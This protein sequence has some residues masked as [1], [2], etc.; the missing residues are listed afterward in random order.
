VTAFALF[1]TSLDL[2]FT[3]TGVAYAN[4]TRGNNILCIKKWPYRSQANEDK[5]PTLL[6]YPKTPSQPYSKPP[7][8]WGFGS[9]SLTERDD[10]DKDFVEWFKIYLD[11]RVLQ[12]HQRKDP[13]GAPKLQSH[14]DKWYEDYFRLLY[15]HIELKLGSELPAHKPW[16]SAKVEF[17]V[18]LPTTWQLYPTVEKF[19][20]IIDRAGYCRYPSHSVAMGLTE[21]EAA[22]VHT[23][24][25]AAGMFNENEA[26][27][28]CDAGGGTTDLSVLRIT[29]VY[30]GYLSLQQLDVVTGKNIGSVAIDRQFE[31]YVA[32]KLQ[33]ATSMFN[34]RIDPLVTAWS[35]VRS[36]EYQN[37]KCDYGSPD[38]TPIFT[39]PI[40]RINPAFSSEQF[41]IANG[42]MKFQTEELKAIFD[43]QIT[44]LFAEIDNQLQSFQNKFPSDQIGHLVLSGGLGNS[45]YVQGQLKLR[46]AFG[47]SQFYC[48]QNIQIHVAPE[49]QLAVCKGIVSDRLRKLQ[50]GK[51]VLEWRCARASYGTLCKIL[52]DKRNP[53]H[54]SRGSFRDPLNGKYYI[55]NAIVWFVKKVCDLFQFA[56]MR[57]INVQN[58]VNLLT[59]MAIL[60]TS[61]VERLHR[62]IRLGHF[63]QVW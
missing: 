6:V 57:S 11:P 20:S 17:I 61:S 56:Q 42:T 37:A 31:D 33:Q 35:M 7:S 18:S 29:G 50:S 25:E 36:R 28:V 46:Y 15:Q 9:E 60:S 10:K 30:S 21:P 58:R 32:A 44:R 23:S 38:M 3:G 5:V 59:W 43:S 2:E 45:A 39:V 14:I 34:L 51:A 12:D 8:S 63:Q 1:R 54:V 47:M 62:V 24:M 48:A 49:P 13:R 55:N 52:Y 40:P 26:V 41:N 4:L 19:K 53:D 27:L 22:A 16:H